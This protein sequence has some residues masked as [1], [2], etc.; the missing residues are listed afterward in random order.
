ML[1][2]FDVTHNLASKT[3]INIFDYESN[4]G[5]T[6][7]LKTF[8][9]GG[10]LYTQDLTDTEQLKLKTML[11]S[12]SISIEFA[13]DFGQYLTKQINVTT[14]KFELNQTYFEDSQAMNIDFEFAELEKSIL[15]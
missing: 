1:E 2:T 5:R 4:L 15:L 9:N 13:D 10:T 12:P 6:P 3:N 8:R 11:T 7:Y 14:S